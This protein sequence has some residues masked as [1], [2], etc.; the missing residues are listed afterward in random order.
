MDVFLPLIIGVYLLLSFSDLS[1]H[2]TCRSAYGGSYFGCHSRYS[3]IK[4]EYPALRKLS[5]VIALCSIGLSA[6]RQ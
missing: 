6:M 1:H 5:L 3:P 2:R 4:V